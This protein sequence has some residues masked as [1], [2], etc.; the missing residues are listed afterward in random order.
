M[1]K[2]IDLTR[3]TEITYENPVSPDFYGDLKPELV[4]TLNELRDN[5]AMEKPTPEQIQA[6]LDNSVE[7]ENLDAETLVEQIEIEM[8]SPIE[9]MDEIDAEDDAAPPADAGTSTRH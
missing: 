2:M 8:P 5:S 4:Q 3:I 9:A 6:M 7:A 1:V